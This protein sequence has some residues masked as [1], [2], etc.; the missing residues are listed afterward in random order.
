MEQ[1]KKIVWGSQARWRL[2]IYSYVLR[3]Y[4]IV[5]VSRTRVMA[6]ETGDIRRLNSTR[7]TDK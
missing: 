2:A 6:T 3:S 7:G 5:A 1:P 4:T